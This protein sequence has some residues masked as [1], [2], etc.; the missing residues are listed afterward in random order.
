MNQSFQHYSDEEAQ[1][2]LRQSIAKQAQAGGFHSEHA[3]DEGLVAPGITS[4]QL[5]KMAAELGISAEVVRET[6]QNW[7]LRQAEE[8]DMKAFIAHRRQEFTEHLYAYGIVNAFLLAINYFTEHRITWAIFPLLG[9]GL[10][11]LFSAREAYVTSGEEFDDEFEKWRE[12]RAK[13]RKRTGNSS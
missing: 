8:A 2:I 4:D 3:Q 12:K 13:K 5:A 6:E 1:E 10:G 7:Q 11:L 9:W